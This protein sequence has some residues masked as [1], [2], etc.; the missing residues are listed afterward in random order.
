MLARMIIPRRIVAAL[1]VL[2][3][4]DASLV[5]AS[6]VTASPAT[7]TGV[8]YG[9]DVSGWQHN[10]N[11]SR[12]YAKGARFAYVK[13]TE[14]TGYTNPYFTQQY[15][16]SYYAGMIRGAYHFARPD[17]SSGTAQA[18]YFVNH[19]GGWSRDGKTLPGALDIE[20]NPY[21]GGMCYGRSKSGMAGWIRAFSTEYHAR[22]TRYPVIYTANNWW[23]RWVGTAGNFTAT[24][25]LWVAHYS[26]SVGTLPYPWA[27]QTFWQTSDSGRFS[28]DQDRFNGAYSQLRR[29]ANG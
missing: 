7:A 5:T 28:G 8:V 2:A 24:S 10:V 23:S 20:W 4:A 12:A 9:M 21:R 17:I 26:T 3:L 14:G 11:W 29:I 16:G 1:L 25:P 22:T 13:A 19:G 18:D 15:E 27:Y 6:L